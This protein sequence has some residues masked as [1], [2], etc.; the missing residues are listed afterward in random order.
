MRQATLVYLVTMSRGVPFAVYLGEKKSRYVAGWLNTAGGKV[1]PGED[2]RS[3]GA[4]EMLQE[5]NVT[6]DPVNLRSVALLHFCFPATPEKD[7]ECHVFF[8]ESW[9]GDPQ[10]S[11][12]IGDPGLFPAAT[13]PW[14]RL[15]PADR[16]WLPQ[17]LDGQ[18]VQMRI[19]LNEDFTPRTVTERTAHPQTP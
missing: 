4:R 5:W 1:D 18:F 16:E 14:D 13:L 7:L 15:P 8:A 10:G 6:V 3:S 2:I 17:V 12:E 11:E 9:V 19:E